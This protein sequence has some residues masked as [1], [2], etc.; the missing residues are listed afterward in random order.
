MKIS[1]LLLSL[2][3][4]TNVF[5]QK[6]FVTAGGKTTNSTGSVSYSIGQIGY[7]NLAG[8]KISNGLQ[9][10]FEILVLGNN[11]FPEIALE[12]SVYPNPATENL[13]LKFENDFDKKTYTLYDVNGRNIIELEKIVSLETQISLNKL[14]QGIYFLDILSDAKKIKTFKILKK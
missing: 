14:P 1:I 8:S 9:Q 2:G 4:F 7:K 3:L 5:S 13:V 10:P 6:N 11:A 12:M